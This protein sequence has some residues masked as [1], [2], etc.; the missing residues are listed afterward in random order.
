MGVHRNN[1]EKKIKK[2][3]KGNTGKIQKHLKKLG[4]LLFLHHI[5]SVV[6]LSINA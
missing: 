1:D 3:S 4:I 6:G 2:I 5:K